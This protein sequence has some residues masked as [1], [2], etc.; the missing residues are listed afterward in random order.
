MDILP[1]NRDVQ[2]NIQHINILLFILWE[3]NM[4]EKLPVNFLN[5]FNSNG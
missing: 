5:G 4:Q 1:A 3:I 2:K